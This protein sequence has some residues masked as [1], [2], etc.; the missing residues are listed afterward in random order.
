MKKMIQTLAVAAAALALA[1]VCPLARAS[2]NTMA[3]QKIGQVDLQK[4][5]E[6]YYK[7]VRLQA[8]LKQEAADLQ[9]ER[10][11]MID[12]GKKLEGEWQKLLD[13]SED[14]AVSA[15]ERAKSKKAAE[16]KFR[17][18]KAAEQAIQEYDRTSA[19]RLEEKRR[20]RH[21]D[22]VHEIRGVLEAQAKAAHYTLV[23]DV[24]G[25]SANTVPV[26]IYSTGLNDLTEGVI[27]ELNAGAPA[28]PVEEPASKS[29]K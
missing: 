20:Q 17:E 22:I 2:T 29:G 12:N 14:Q 16:D 28:A 13:K 1:S 19:A 8:A 3:E 9:K 15:E 26:V 7:T 27:K 24:S 4:V 23:L 11:D 21:D 10:N 25:D 5:F 6:K 18:V